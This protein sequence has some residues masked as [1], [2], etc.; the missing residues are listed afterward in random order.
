MDGIRM[1]SAIFRQ[2]WPLK[3][4]WGTKILLVPIAPYYKKK[5]PKICPIPNV[6]L[7]R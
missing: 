5:K 6:K 3:Q 1:V 2:C 4:F 7:H